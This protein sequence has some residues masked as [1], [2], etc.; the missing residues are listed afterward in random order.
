MSN[1]KERISMNRVVKVSLWLAFLGLFAMGLKKKVKKVGV[2]SD[3]LEKF[4]YICG[5]KAATMSR[6]TGHKGSGET[7]GIDNKK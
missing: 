2:Q 4:L 3:I 1:I 5:G 6:H 7:A